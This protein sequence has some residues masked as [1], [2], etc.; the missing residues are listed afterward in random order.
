[1]GYQNESGSVDCKACQPCAKGKKR[2]GCGKISR[3]ECPSCLQGKY[4][5]VVGEHHTKCD[6]CEAGKFGDKLK[7]QD[8]ESHCQKCV[9]GQYQPSSAATSCLACTPCGD[10]K[11][12]GGSCK[13]DN[14]GQ[15]QACAAGRSKSGADAWDATCTDCSDGKFQN[16]QGQATCKTCQPCGPGLKRVRCAGAKAGQCVSCVNGRFKSAL[17]K[18]GAWDSSCEVC[19][20]GKFSNGKSVG[21]PAT[22]P[23]ALTR[24]QL[25]DTKIRLSRPRARRASPALLVT[26][27]RRLL[28]CTAVVRLRQVCASSV[29]LA[30]LRR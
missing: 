28:R 5:D 15:G 20:T 2:V 16:H 14:A 13:D 24:A 17:P 26:F 23:Q 11:F 10:G 3:G 1:M 30:R 8:A 19:P 22:G 27:A 7:K 21:Q 4:K 18:F 9:D 6:A 29:L 12:L 25:A